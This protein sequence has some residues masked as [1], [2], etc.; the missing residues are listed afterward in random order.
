[1]KAPFF[2]TGEYEE[3][4]M[5]RREIRESIFQLL[6]MTEFNDNQEMAEQKQLYLETIEDIQ[7]KDQS[8]I[9]E[10][11]EKIREKLPEIDAALNEAS[12][13]WK[14]SRMGKV[15]LSIL[16][17]AVY[18]LRY[19]DD[20]PGKVAINEAVELAKK[21]GGSEAPAFINGVLGKLAKEADE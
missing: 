17:L 8:Y 15:E 3:K 14:T 5:G 16:R 18:E 21:F 4:T 1:M 20:V 11:Y 2:T 10:K 13:G 6:F 12:K 19:D 7:E 9:Q